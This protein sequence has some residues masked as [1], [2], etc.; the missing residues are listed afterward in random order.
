MRDADVAMKERLVIE[1]EV[2]HMVRLIDDLLDVSRITRGTIVLSR[3]PIE[4]AEVV[5]RA[6]EMASPLIEERAHRLT[7]VVS[8]TALLVDADP[9]RLSQAIS[10][11]LSNA[12][13]YTQNGGTIAIQATKVGRR[14][15]LSVQDNGFGIDPELSPRIF[16]AF[17]Q[18]RQALC[19]SSGGLG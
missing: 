16:E 15:E 4:L 14:V 8:E 13:K 1:R 7:T 9:Y 19:R 3:Q 17:V 11:L 5:T 6:I 12:A 2:H 10:N 18:G